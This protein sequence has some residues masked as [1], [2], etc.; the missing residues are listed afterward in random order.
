M[1]LLSPS[2]WVLFIAGS[3]AGAIF[4]FFLCA[5]LTGMQTQRSIRVCVDKS[6]RLDRAADLHRAARSQTF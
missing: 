3:W 2:P 1:T 6:T 5:L 4:G